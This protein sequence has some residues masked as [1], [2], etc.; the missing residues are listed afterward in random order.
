MD[1]TQKEITSSGL[2]MADIEESYTMRIPLNDDELNSLFGST[3]KYEK[4][5]DGVWHLVGED[6]GIARGKLVC[7]GGGEGAGKTRFYLQIAVFLVLSGMRVVIF[8]LEMSNEE[9]KETLVNLCRGHG[10]ELTDD[11]LSR[12]H[13]FGKTDADGKAAPQHFH[14][15]FQAKVVQEISPDLAVVDSYWLMKDRRTDDDINLL[16]DQWKRAIGQ[17]TAAWFIC[18]LNNKGGIKGNS[19][20]RYMTDGWMAFEKLPDVAGE[21]QNRIKAANGKNRN[22]KPTTVYMQHYNNGVA[23]LPGYVPPEERTS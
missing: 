18:P 17:F 14:P 12:I 9:I 10:I 8:Q 15:A 13:V 1:D 4:D 3:K 23:M 7:I 11:Q 5:S 2:T 21:P 22:G 6:W 19:H 20:I 16:V